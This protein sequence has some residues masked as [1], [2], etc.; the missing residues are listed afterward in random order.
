[1]YDYEKT[2]YRPVGNAT[3][4][5]NC[6]LILEYQRNQLAEMALEITRKVFE[7]PGEE[8]RYQIWLAERNRRLG[9]I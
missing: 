5:I 1:M 4:K 7:Q 6:S 3:V 2:E 9:K 8:E